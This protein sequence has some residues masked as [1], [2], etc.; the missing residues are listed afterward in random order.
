MFR[1][2]TT[3]PPAPP[4]DDRQEVPGGPVEP[5][6][7]PTLSDL[8]AIWRDRD[9]QYA[10]ATRALTE[11]QIEA[12]RAFRIKEVNDLP[13]ALRARAWGIAKSWAPP[14]HG[15]GTG[16]DAPDGLAAWA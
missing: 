5:G 4:A 6:T 16:D 9:V 12:I 1:R 2:P 11:D 8:V 3:V 14:Q 15:Q 13:P 10:K 7:P